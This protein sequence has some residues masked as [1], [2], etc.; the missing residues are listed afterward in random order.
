MYDNLVSSRRRLLIDCRVHFGSHATRVVIQLHPISP[1]V[2]EVALVGTVGSIV[3]PSRTPRTSGTS[4]APTAQTRERDYGAH[5]RDYRFGSA[6]AEDRAEGRQACG[7]DGY[8]GLH[9]RPDKDACDD[10]C[11]FL[12]KFLYIYEGIELTA[13][14]FGACADIFVEKSV[15]VVDPHG[16]GDTAAVHELASTVDDW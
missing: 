7:N 4:R 8:A 15:E 16:F 12:A 14:C 5:T 2:L 6:T 10:G 1:R 3:G 13:K 11:D 9:T